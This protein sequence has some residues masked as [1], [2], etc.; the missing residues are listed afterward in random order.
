M[1]SGTVTIKIPWSALSGVIAN[2]GP[3]AGFVL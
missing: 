2:P 3:A 1:A